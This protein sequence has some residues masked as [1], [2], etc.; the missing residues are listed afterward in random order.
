MSRINLD[1]QE[2]VIL[3]QYNYRNSSLIIHFFLSQFGRINAIAKGVK[4]KVSKQSKTRKI[5]LYS[6]RLKNCLSRSLEN[7][8]Y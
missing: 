6:N 1:N 4:S 2:A 8:I 3:H 7:R 5:T